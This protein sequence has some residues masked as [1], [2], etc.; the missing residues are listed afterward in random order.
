ML[1]ETMP[2]T[3]AWGNAFVLDA[4]QTGANGQTNPAGDLMRV[5]AL[6]NNSVVTV[7]GNP[8]IT[9]SAGQFGDTT[10]KGP[11]LVSSSG[12]LLVG[13]I[14]H[15]DQAT[16][17]NGDPFLA[18]VPPVDQTYNN[19]TFFISSDNNFQYQSVVIAAD[20]TCVNNITLDGQLLP[21]AAFTSIPG[22][23]NGRS[24]SILEYPQL[25]GSHTI[26]TSAQAAQGFSIL[27]Y[28]V[29]TEVSYGYTAGELLV[30]KRT[31]RIEYPPEVMNGQHSNVLNFHNTSYQPAYLDSAIF[32]PDNPDASAFGIHV[33]EDVATDIGRMDVGAS[34]QIHLISDNPLPDPISGTVTIYSHLP[35]YLLIE[36]AVMHFTLYPNSAAD[37][38]PNGT[39][40]L[41]ATATPNPF[42]TSTTINFSIPTT[43]DITLTLY[44][45]LGRVVQHVASGEYPGGQYSI[46]IYRRGLANG[47][48]VCEI[49]SDKL[50]IHTRVPIVAG[51]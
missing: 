51:E 1:L 47:V 43:G 6:N 39:L 2:P 41:T 10:V 7:N 49:T 18:I 50:N 11:T 9:L 19:Y 42:S 45:E 48:Y 29:G 37:V 27:A 23:V 31:I 46:P 34:S 4:I 13:E 8:W 24:F 16:G 38:S 35:S 36:P 20:N 44:D 5:L 33:Q 26:S 14:E 21:A 40:A 32:T 15:S 25:G 12:P 3:S 28:G 22:T 17:D 30:P